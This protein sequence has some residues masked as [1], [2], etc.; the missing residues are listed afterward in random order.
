M[1]ILNENDILWESYTGGIEYVTNSDEESDEIK[2]EAF[3]KGVKIGDA[4]AKLLF[5]DFYYE[6]DD[7]MSEDDVYE[8]FP[9]NILAKIE[10]VEVS[11]QYR[12]SGIAK[13]M[14]NRLLGELEQ[15]G[16]KQLY[17]NASPMGINK[18]FD[19]SELVNFYQKFGFDILL[20]QGGNTLM[21]KK[22]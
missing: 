5:G 2:I 12:G 17:L 6:F 7:V 13:E 21:I 14:M 4:I 15:Q 22:L 3:H 11:K 10:H 9:D 18:G 20:D 16:F 8:L 1:I 19:K